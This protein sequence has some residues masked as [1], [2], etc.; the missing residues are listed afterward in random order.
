MWCKH[1]DG[2]CYTKYFPHETVLPFVCIVWHSTSTLHHQMH[3]HMICSSWQRCCRKTAL[4]RKC[5]CPYRLG[6]NSPPY[7]LFFK[8]FLSTAEFFFNFRIFT[9]C[10]RHSN[11]ALIVL[12]AIRF[13]NVH[14]E[15]CNQSSENTSMFDKPPYPKVNVFDLILCLM[16]PLPFGAFSNFFFVFFSDRGQ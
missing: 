16:P 7:L 15:I 10:N 6:K 3:H 1:F 5:S 4:S 11:H 12:I 14:L 8:H 9:I 13:T 2:W